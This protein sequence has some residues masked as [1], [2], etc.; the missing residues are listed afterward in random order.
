MRSDIF[1]DGLLSRDVSFQ[2]NSFFK[3]RVSPADL[4]ER[5]QQIHLL[6]QTRIPIESYKLAM[7]IA[8]DCVYQG[9]NA[10]KFD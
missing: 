1:N 9:G 3:I 2:C 6:D 10:E 5:Q 4:N 8:S 7:K